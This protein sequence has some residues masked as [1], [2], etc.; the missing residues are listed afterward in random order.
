MQLSTILLVAFGLYQ[1]DASSPLPGFKPQTLAKPHQ[2]SLRSSTADEVK[3][4]FGVSS[5]NAGIYYVAWEDSVG[6][7][8]LV[9]RAIIGTGPCE[10][11]FNLATKDGDLLPLLQLQ[12]CHGRGTEI[13]GDT[14]MLQGRPWASCELMEKKV[15]DQCPANP[16]DKGEDIIGTFVCT[17]AAD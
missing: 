3:I 14:L 6:P 8:N 7:C 9:K 1:T 15:T 10:A 5:S 11:V 2:T 12:N 17:H 13:F 4:E 16:W